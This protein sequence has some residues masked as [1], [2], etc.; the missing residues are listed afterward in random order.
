MTAAVAPCMSCRKG[1]R[2]TALQR[3][4]RRLR[5]LVLQHADWETTGSYGGLLDAYGRHTEIVRLDRGDPVPDWRE[6]DAI[7]AMGGP[8]SVNDHAELP[9]LARETALV[10]A[11]VAAGRPFF[12]VC[13]GAQILAAA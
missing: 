7:V 12:G 4:G 2:R 9:W 3:G 11:A 8:M 10:A 6:F 5:Y 13:L 1:G